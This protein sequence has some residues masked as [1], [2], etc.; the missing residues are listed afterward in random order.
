MNRDNPISPQWHGILDYMLG[1]LFIL[2]PWLVHFNN[3]SPV[4]TVLM[5]L[6]GISLIGISMF[7]NYPLGMI[8]SFSFKTHRNIETVLAVFILISPWLLRYQ[9]VPSATRMAVVMSV[10][11]LIAIVMTNYQSRP[12]TI[13]HL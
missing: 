10:M 9:D 13:S 11:W 1:I 5:V 8:H 3:F 6:A 7:T 4:A 2:S 12:K